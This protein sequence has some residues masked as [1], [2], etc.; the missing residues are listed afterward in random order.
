[1]MH[2]EPIIMWS[3]FVGGVGTEPKTPNA[4]PRRRSWRNGRWDTT[5]LP[6]PL[7]DQ[8]SA[9]RR[10]RRGM[11]GRKEQDEVPKADPT[12]TNRCDGM[13]RRPCCTSGL[14]LPAVVIPIREAL[15]SGANIPQAP[16]SPHQV[17]SALSG[18]NK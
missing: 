1:M 16:P 17:A 7:H 9:T 11:V 14:M 4:R 3:C 8:P 12:M 5:A 15:G 18:K 13:H 2:E 10:R 6:R